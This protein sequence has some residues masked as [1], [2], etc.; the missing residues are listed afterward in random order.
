M[1]SFEVKLRRTIIQTGTVNVMALSQAEAEAMAENI[2][3][4]LENSKPL[5]DEFIRP[6]WELDDDTIEVEEVN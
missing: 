1:Q 5:P 6:D 2:A 3:D 4:S